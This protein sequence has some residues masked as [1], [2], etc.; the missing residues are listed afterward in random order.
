LAATDEPVDKPPT[1]NRDADT[2]SNAPALVGHWRVTEATADGEP[3][4]EG[5]GEI[6]VF[7]EDGTVQTVGHDFEAHQEYR[8]DMS[9]RPNELVTFFSNPAHA[10]VGIFELKG[11]RLRWRVADDP[12]PLSFDRDPTG[13]WN[14][15]EMTRI[16]AEQA[17]PLIEALQDQRLR[18][19]AS[20]P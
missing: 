1:P 18:I 17:A 13:R 2:E 16:T 19:K 6:H 3:F 14:E 11:D 4:A 10:G 12:Q 15:Y 7:K 9:K 5:F 8:C 20:N